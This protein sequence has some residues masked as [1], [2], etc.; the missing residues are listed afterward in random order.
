MQV[1]EVSGKRTAQKWFVYREYCCSGESINCKPIHQIRRQTRK[2]WNQIRWTI[3][4]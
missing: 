3:S 2:L 1:E 4:C